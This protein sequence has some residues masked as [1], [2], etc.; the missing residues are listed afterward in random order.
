MGDKDPNVVRQIQTQ[1]QKMQLQIQE[2]I[3]TSGHEHM[4]EEIP[5]LSARIEE[6]QKSRGEAARSQ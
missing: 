6:K 1:I 5:T 3:Q 4:G 2:Q